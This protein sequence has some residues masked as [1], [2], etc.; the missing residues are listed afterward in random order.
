MNRTVRGGRTEGRAADV[1]TDSDA[2]SPT[3]GGGLPVG[4]AI[5]H[6]D[7]RPV[8]TVHFLR[9]ERRNAAAWHSNALGCG[10]VAARCRFRSGVSAPFLR[11]YES[12]PARGVMPSASA[13]RPIGRERYARAGAGARRDPRSR[14]GVTL[15]SGEHLPLRI[16]ADAATGVVDF[17]SLRAP[18][19]E[20]PA[21]SRVVAHGDGSLYTFSMHQ[22]PDMPDELFDA[23]V[24]ELERELTV[25]KAH[26][27]SSCPCTRVCGVAHRPRGGALLTRRGQGAR[28]RVARRR[29][30]RT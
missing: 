16:D 14:V 13:S 3:P 28:R 1:S 9:R 15:A 25:L 24:A 27:E 22:G 2:R 10:F 23:Q 21:H 19:V 6:D 5:P 12:W 17:V 20:A 18:G 8:E 26:L 30:G 29:P 4:G 7:R 11:A